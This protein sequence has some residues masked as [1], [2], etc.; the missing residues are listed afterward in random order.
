MSDDALVAPGE[1]SLDG[2]VEIVRTLL[3]L[4][5]APGASKAAFDAL[6]ARIG[7]RVVSSVKGVGLPTVRIPDPGSLEALKG[8]AASLSADPV[9]DGADL[10]AI[11]PPEDLPGNVAAASTDLE[12]IRP[13]LAVRSGAAWNAR[14]ALDTPPT[15]LLAD[16]F[17]DGPPDAA[18]TALD[19]RP[20]DFSTPASPYSAADVKQSHGYLVAGLLAGRFE[21]AGAGADSAGDLRRGH[22][23][24]P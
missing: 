7:A 9:L 13:Q 15:L 21:P 22:V 3:E 12:F 6:L 2:G 20:G 11:P 18:L 5:L 19:A 16:Y 8:L 4:D 10:V 17:G 14:A 23:G 1:I 24:G